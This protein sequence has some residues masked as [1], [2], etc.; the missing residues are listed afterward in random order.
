[1]S[2]EY[3]GKTPDSN[4]GSDFP[5]VPQDDSS[6][7]QTPDQAE[8]DTVSDAPIPDQAGTATVLDAGETV[9]AEDAAPAY[10]AMPGPEAAA[11]PPLQPQQAPQ[12]YT[13][14]IPQPPAGYAPGAQQQPYGQQ[15]PAGYYAP[16]APQQPYGY[17]QAGYQQPQQPQQPPYG[18]PQGGYQQPYGQQQ[19][20]GYQQP[21]QGGYQQ[22]PQPPYPPAG[23]QQPYGYQ[24]YPYQ[25][26]QPP[27]KK[28]T[29]LWVLIGVLLVLMLGFGGCVGCAV[30][31]AMVED[32]ISSSSNRDYG[33]DYDYDYDYDFD[34]YSSTYSL[35]EILSMKEYYANT[36]TDGVCSDGVFE[37]GAGKDIPAGTYFL[38]GSQTEEGYYFAYSKEG[39]DSYEMTESVVYFGNYFVILEEGDIIVFDPPSSETMYSADKASL[40]DQQPY[41]SGLYRVGTDLPA[42][43]YVISYQTSAAEAASGDPAAFI[44][45]DLDWDDDSIT[46]EYYVLNGTPRTI[47]VTDGQWLE[48]YAVTMVPQT[49]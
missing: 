16:D 39:A 37:V 32:E 7:P 12:G 35:E 49:A 26:A 1:M 45:K 34:G 2:E 25:G 23:Y 33:Y 48:L 11:M 24:Q 14:D 6:S 29:W 22:P 4:P 40:S 27:A 10:T 20:Y 30:M 18:Q 43:E 36:V 47:T 41:Q 42:G 44:M 28:R 8:V 3:P 13:Q 15:P 46:N 9:R 31:T 38:E 19:P 17:Q 21:Q 5:T